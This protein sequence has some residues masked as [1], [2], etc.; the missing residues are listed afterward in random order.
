[1]SS[2]KEKFNQISPSE[3]FYRNRDLAGFSDPSRSLY[4]A[5]REFVE[6]GL[7]ACDQIGILPDLRLTI[8]AVDPDQPDPK[9]YILTVKDNGPGI[10]PKHI[11]L[12]F[13]VV[14]Y[15]SKF[16]L[17][18][19]RGMFGLGATMAILYGQITINKPVTIKSSTD[20]KISDECELLLDI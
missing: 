1:M 20:G 17:K 4:T 10:E 8:K 15:G 18:Q 11:P 19:A 6:N 3:L 13:G 14:L 2:I 9:P 7:D 12:A 16:G 5:V